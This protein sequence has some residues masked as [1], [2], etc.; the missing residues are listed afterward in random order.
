VI[1]RDAD[2]HLL[3]GTSSNFY[4]VLRDTLYT[5]H[6]GV[7]GG[8]ARQIVYE[9]APSV[10]P[11]VRRSVSITDLEALQEAFISSSSRGVVPVVEIDGHRLG[12]GTPGR[13]TRQIMAA[14]AAWVQSHLETL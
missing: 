12:D 13:Y 2:N 4:A 10:L 6:E 9:V 11:L 1:L 14:Y 3:E 8:T 7:L 5:A